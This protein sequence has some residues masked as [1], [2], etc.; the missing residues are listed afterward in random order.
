[1]TSSWAAYWLERFRPV[2]FIPA[3]LVVAAAASAGTG[4]DP[5]GWTVD[6]LGALLLL[7]QFRLWDDLADRARDRATHPSRVLVR[8]TRVAPF[9]ATCLTLAIVNVVLAAWLR[10]TAAAAAVVALDVAA[11][12]WYTWRPAQRSAAT[13]LVLLTKYPAFVLL[14]AVGSTSSFP[15]T[16]LSA[17]AIYVLAC[18]FEV[19]HDASGPL[20][21]TN[22]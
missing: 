1:V 18:A 9:I 22:S 19:W 4:I 13:D 10:G 17:T 20:R 14:L 16:V 3:A 12:A 11:A 5:R 21:A 7:G 15:L 2:L 6:T 8:A